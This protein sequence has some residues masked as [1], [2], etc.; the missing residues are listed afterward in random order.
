[1]IPQVTLRE[2]KQTHNGSKIDETLKGKKIKNA[3]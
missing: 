1:M 2:T 3:S